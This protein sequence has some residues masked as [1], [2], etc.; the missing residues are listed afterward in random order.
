MYRFILCPDKL[1][2]L[3]VVEWGE[4]G[5]MPL[6]PAGPP[7]SSPSQPTE[8]CTHFQFQHG[9]SDISISLPQITAASSSTGV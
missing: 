3:C 5:E 1:D 4:E 2:H 8:Y 6:L 9:D 7:L